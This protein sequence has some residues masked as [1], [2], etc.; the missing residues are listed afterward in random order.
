MKRIAILLTTAMIAV[1]SKS[2]IFVKSTGQTIAENAVKGCAV[3]VK[4]AYQLKDD[5]TGKAYGRHGKNEFGCNYTIGVKTNKGLII[6]DN[7]IRP[8]NDDSN[9]KK[10]NGNYTPVI[11]RTEVRDFSVSEKSEFK[12]QPLKLAANQ[13]HGLYIART[14]DSTP[15]GM[16]IDYT[17]GKKKGWLIWYESEK[18]INEDP[19]S[20]ISIN[21]INNEMEFK[22]GQTEYEIDTPTNEKDVIGGIYVCPQ[23]RGNGQINFC[24]V[25]IIALSD[26]KWKLT[27]PFAS[28]EESFKEKPE[29]SEVKEDTSQDDDPGLTPVDTPTK[30]DKKNKKNKR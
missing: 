24:L 10:I 2:Q 27:A 21:S 23:F 14:D 7:A 19:N 17:S 6:T 15:S 16:E 13:P 18:N 25:G 5:K 26:G 9:Y 29:I 30:K 3:I 12:Q 22:E 28:E 4:Q 1:S 8:W 11:S 20:S